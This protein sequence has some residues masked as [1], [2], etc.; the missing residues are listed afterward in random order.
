[1]IGHI[2]DPKAQAGLDRRELPEPEAADDQ[3]VIQVRAYAV[4]RGELNLLQQ[5]LDGWMPGQDVSGVVVKAARDGSGPPVGRRVVGI[6]D[7][8]GWS[9][10][11][12]V[13]TYRVAAI[14]DSVSF[15]DAAPLGVAGLT[16]L[17]ALRTGGP[18]N[19]AKV[20]VTGA[21]GGV[22]HFAVQLA[23]VEGAHVT[24]HV[25]GPHRLDTVRALGADEVVTK[26][27]ESVGPFNLVVDGVGGQTLVDAIRRL[28]PGGTVSAYGNA[29]GEKAQLVFGD[30]RAAP[31]GCLKG[32]FVYGTDQR[33]FGEDLGYMARLL[34]E[35]K[36]NVHSEVREDWAQTR[37]AIDRLRQHAATG[38]V[39]LTID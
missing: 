5:R 27:D 32:F 34:A 35:E 33:T 39:V 29:S 37:E 10:V 12:P 9:Q 14:P 26:I 21:S 8:G 23:K 25:S 31:G 3:V 2:T 19:G 11:V 28:A 18:L 20:L 15:G 38:K 24:G 4:N 6:V 22:G 30:F 13:S 1:M 17:R 36:L 7:G 16:A